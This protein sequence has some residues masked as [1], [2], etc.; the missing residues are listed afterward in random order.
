[1]ARATIIWKVVARPNTEW[2]ELPI[3]KYIIVPYRVSTTFPYLWYGPVKL[4]Q[5]PGPYHKD[6]TL[7]RSTIMY[8][9]LY[10]ICSTKPSPL[11]WARMSKIFVARVS[12]SQWS[13]SP[14]RQKKLAAE[15][16]NWFRVSAVLFCRMFYSVL[17]RSSSTSTGT[18]T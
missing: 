11:C 9:V 8:S 4:V 1:M 14:A 16:R 18:F 13:K 2:S 6:G 12:F 17:R 15:T 5:V 7:V 10:D 3:V